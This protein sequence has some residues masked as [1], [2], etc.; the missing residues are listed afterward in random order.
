MT[1][2]AVGP[3]PSL[4]RFLRCRRAALAALLLALTSA[5]AWAIITDLDLVRALHDPAAGEHGDQLTFWTLVSSGRGDEAFELAFETGDEL[6]ETRFNALDGV[7][8]N[9]GAG[10]RFTRVPRADLTGP[11][12]WANHVPRRETGPNAESCSACH[13]VPFDDGAGL[14]ASNVHRDPLHS[15]NLGSFVQR[16]TPHLFAAGAIQ[17]LAEEMTETLHQIRAD[18]MNVVY[19][20][21]GS[22]TV[23]LVAKGISFGSLTCTRIGREP[24]RTSLDVSGVVG[25]DADLVVRPFQWKGSVPFLRDFNRGAAH[26]ELG[27]QS[28]ELVGDGVDG[29]SD[30]VAD[31]LTIGDQTALA[32]YLAAQPRPVTLLELDELGLLD[33]PLTSAEEDEI[34]RG[35]SA[36]AEI[37]CAVCH[38]PQLKIEDPRFSEPSQNP[39]YRDATFPA[40][41]DP[42]AAGLDPAQ[43]ITF[44]LTRDQPDNR[45][46]GPRGEVIRLGSLR[47]DLRGRGVVELFGDLKRHDLGPRLAESIDEVGTGAATFLTENLWGVGSTAQYLHDGRATTLTEAILEHGGEAASSRDAF[48]ALPTARQMDLI[49]FLDNLVLFKLEEDEKF[50]R[51]VED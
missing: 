11:G 51:P 42:V 28:V 13:G 34:R 44:D 12:E 17:R 37:G 45:I 31:E 3:R 23:P 38:V 19:S 35:R 10:Q 47:A 49:A 50:R 4:A 7:G 43:A 36:F 25:V 20:A 6:F 29:D 9:V 8:A 40:R 41:Q 39:R 32:V 5:T 22:L 27:M 18:A 48:V 16:N 15:A 14:S 46:T 24:Y 30:G 33:P 21:G 1:R 2:F 26:N